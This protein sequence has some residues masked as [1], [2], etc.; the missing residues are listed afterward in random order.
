MENAAALALRLA[1]AL[2]DAIMSDRYDGAE[3]AQLNTAHM[4]VTSLLHLLTVNQ[5]EASSDIA[6]ETG[7]AEQQLREG[8]RRGI[9][10]TFRLIDVLNNLLE[11]ADRVL[12]PFTGN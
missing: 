11:P 9:T 2:Y 12:V 10:T 3:R 7:N 4:I 8:E 6:D 1:N 5:V